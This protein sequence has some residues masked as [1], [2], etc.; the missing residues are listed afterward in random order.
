[1]NDSSKQNDVNVPADFPRNPDPGSISGF[2]PK[3]LAR[4]I[5]E[6]F[7]VGYTPEE[8]KQ[9]YLYCQDLVDQLVPYCERKKREHPDWSEAYLLEQIKAS[10]HR[11]DWG[12]SALE[13]D[14]MVSQLA[15]EPAK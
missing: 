10:L 2:Q 5:G 6:K 3:L 13:I 8:V 15:A 7:V 12:L 11:K 4:R 14:W 1:M 9:R